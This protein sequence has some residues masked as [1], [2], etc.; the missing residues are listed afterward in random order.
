MATTTEQIPEQS[1]EQTHGQ[2]PNASRQPGPEQVAGPG[3]ETAAG[4][5]D[6]APRSTPSGEGPEPA[7]AVTTAAQRQSLGRY[8][9][10]IAARH[11]VSA[12]MTLLDR[13]WRGRTGEVDLVLR[14]GDELV[15]CEVKTRTSDACGSPH[16]AVGPDKLARLGGLAEEWLEATGVRP[17]GVRIDLV[18]VLRPRRGAARVEH[19]RGLG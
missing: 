10:D 8:G 2:T 6:P 5:A 3:A 1:P 18:A 13:N 7:R 15:V 19:V 17:G 11:L 4:P 12:G 16:E 14:D 9:E